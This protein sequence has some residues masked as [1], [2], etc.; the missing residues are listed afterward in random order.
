MVGIHEQLA[1][2]FA[3]GRFEPYVHYI[4]FPRY[5]NLLPGTKVEFGHPVTAIV[6]PNGVNKTSVLRALYGVPEGKSTGTYWFATATD[7]MIGDRTTY[8]HGRKQGGVMV[9]VLKQRSAADK[10][11]D[12]WEPSRPVKS[13][14]MADMPPL[15][16]DGSL[17]GRSRT[18]WDPI[19]KDV[20]YLEASDR[21]SAFDRFFHYGGPGSGK[22]QRKELIKRR[23]A[24]L[25]RVIAH[26]H[27]RFSFYRKQR[28]TANQLLTAA[29]IAHVSEI[30]GRKYDEIRWIQHSFYGSDGATVRLKS[31]ALRYTEAFAG[32]GEFAVVQMVRAVLA[33]PDKS[34][35]LLD[36]PETFLH[37]FA[38]GKLMAFLAAQAK[39]KLH[40]VVVTTHAPAIIRDLPRNA[41]K[42]LTL[43]AN[44]EVEIIAQEADPDIAFFHIG[45]PI[46]GKT[47]VYVEDNLAKYVVLRALGKEDAVRAR[48]L[49][50]PLAGG[51]GALWA[52]SAQ[53]STVGRR[54]VRVILDG[55]AR[56]S[57]WPCKPSTDVSDSELDKYISAITG[58][59]LVFYVDGNADGG[60]E[61]QRI[62]LQR[63]FIDWAR[64]YVT[65]LPD[66]TP[67]A[68]ICRAAN[69][70][71]TGD[72]KTFF[73]NRAK[74]SVDDSEVSAATI[75]TVQREALAKVPTDNQEMGV[76]RQF[77]LTQQTAGSAP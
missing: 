58:Q 12:Y 42:V 11:S 31:G 43:S 17:V 24:A 35:I 71:Y 32:S 21:I 6:G 19:K 74:T 68:F 49:V 20:V 44:G 25:Q 60:N 56:P 7:T 67:E 5:K 30:L 18:R 77:L 38:Q 52:F 37:P 75:L 54:D 27:R 28:V 53:F 59:E 26:G 22:P 8:I 2:M 73:V 48:F 29:E 47:T 69:L 33:A 3:A 23:A 55:D 63:K 14:G 4:R 61:A 64:H 34:L 51:K 16:G 45:E 76:L 65:F 13:Y 36:E 41:I 1:K 50:E 9:E 46:A 66:A 70:T 62:V 15:P 39:A 57:E 40:Q 72:A 10:T